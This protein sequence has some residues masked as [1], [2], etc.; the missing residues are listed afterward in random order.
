MV[1]EKIADNGDRAT[2]QLRRKNV[3]EWEWKAAKRISMRLQ[4][5]GLNGFFTRNCPSQAATVEGIAAVLP[6]E[7]DAPCAADRSAGATFRNS[8]S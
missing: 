6:P 3:D 7:G 2:P 8:A 4:P 5:R 1:R